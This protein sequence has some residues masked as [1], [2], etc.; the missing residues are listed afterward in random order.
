MI[1]GGDRMYG[2]VYKTENLV[3]GRMYIGK[4][5]SEYYDESYYG[6]GSILSK[7]ISKYGIENFS[8]EVLY[9]AESLEDLN[10][11]EK[12]YIKEYKEK[13]GRYCY[14][15][16]EGGDGGDTTSGLPEK[17]RNEFISKMTYINR[18][19]CQTEEFREK[20][21]I[22]GKKRYSDSR[23]REVQSIRARAYWNEE[24]CKAHSEK[25]TEYYKTHPKIN[26]GNYKPCI[27]ELG[28]MKIE[29]ECVKDLMSFLSTEYQYNLCRR[30]FKKLME[31]GS[32]GIPYK[33][34]HKNKGSKLEGMLIYYKHDE[35]VTTR[36]DECKP[37]T[38]EIS[39]AGSS[40][41][42]LEIRDED[43]V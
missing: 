5:K 35:S 14:N 22:N 8:N 32:N 26:K 3:N 4:H 23:E 30:T 7:A 27:F 6:S 24:A 40:R 38:A 34:F 2:Y 43:I 16:A 21:S 13:Y 18:K 12:M 37:C 11:A 39:T 9:E 28:S 42:P 19:R 25:M 41:Q 36:A 15:I 1:K 17:E 20:A 31:D 29:F 33:P 10:R